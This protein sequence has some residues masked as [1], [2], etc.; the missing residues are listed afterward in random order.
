VQKLVP[1]ASPTRS[2]PCYL[3]IFYMCLA[4][5]SRGKN[6]NNEGRPHVLSSPDTRKSA[7]QAFEVFRSPC[8][9]HMR[10]ERSRKVKCDVV[11]SVMCM[12]WKGREEEG[13]LKIMHSYQSWSQP[14]RLALALP[15]LLLYSLIHARLLCCAPPTA[16]SAPWYCEQS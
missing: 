3:P 14:D 7:P 8:W 11:E 13:I 4:C 16:D 5:Q 1:Q 12:R 10:R 15:Q 6:Q 9:M 2:R